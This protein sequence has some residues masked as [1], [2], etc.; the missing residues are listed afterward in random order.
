MPTSPVTMQRS[1]Q[2][3]NADSPKK[4]TSKAV[5]RLIKQ[6]KRSIKPVDIANLLA[7]GD[8]ARLCE[9]LAGYEAKDKTVQ[10]QVRA[11]KQALVASK[12]GK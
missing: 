8:G 12:F 11:I 3:T 7:R 5:E 9:L 10:K 1:N 6:Y 2:P 4:D